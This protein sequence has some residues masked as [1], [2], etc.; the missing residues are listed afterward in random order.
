MFALEQNEME[1]LVVEFSV[2]DECKNSLSDYYQSENLTYEEK[3]DFAFLAL[4]KLLNNP[5]KLSL[6]WSYKVSKLHVFIDS[7]DVD[8]IPLKYVP[9][10]FKA[11]KEGSI[12]LTG[13]VMIIRCLEKIVGGNVGYTLS[14]LESGNFGNQSRLALIKKWEDLFEE[15]QSDI[16]KT[17][18]YKKKY[19]GKFVSD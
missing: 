12:M 10:L 15:R 6:L 3:I 13:D 5:Q 1:K 9:I 17:R 8:T 16:V 19:F 7:L 14:Y 4:D 2:C 18:Q 11:L